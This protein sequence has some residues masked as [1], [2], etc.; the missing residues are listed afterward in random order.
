M[1]PAKPGLAGLR[2][3]GWM[4]AVTAEAAGEALEFD[5]ALAPPTAVVVSEGA[6]APPVL[7]LL[8]VGGPDAECGDVPIIDTG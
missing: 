3:T 8:D 4:G 7:E 6:A 2:A 1:V 5:V